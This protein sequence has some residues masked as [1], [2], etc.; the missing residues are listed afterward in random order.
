MTSPDSPR[1][2]RSGRLGLIIPFLLLA[3]FV[4]A[5]SAAWWQESGIVLSRLREAE[6]NG[7]GWRIAYARVNLS[8]F[9]FRLD[10]DFDSP[11]VAEP[12]GWGL[13]AGRLKAEAF[14]FSPTHWVIVAP[15]GVIVTRP[16]Q[17]PLFV[18]AKA[19]R[20]SISEADRHPPRVSVEGLD[21]T[22]S[23]APG[24]RPFFIDSAH[25]LHIHTRSGPA[26]QGAAYLEVDDARTQLSGLLARIA[27]G[28]P[29]SFI[30][31]GV[32]THASALSGPSLG[33]AVRGW[34]DAGG[35]LSVRR[36]R[37]GAGRALIEAR[38]GVLRA[39]PTGRLSGQ[40]S[41]SLRQADAV[42]NGLAGSGGLDAQ[43]GREIGEVTGGAAV[44]T[45]PLALRD[46]R[47]RLGPIDIGPSPRLF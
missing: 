11:R 43:R 15:A 13:Q 31:D 4:V 45:L 29:V 28:G 6:G 18:A 34:S 32:F 2:Q 3:L 38:P 17:G 8:G 10:L 16:R 33:D 26:D 25:E 21:L 44:A 40:L 30:A 23:T 47:V 24:A 39:G 7:P 46:G 9:P 37:L 20:A 42:A 27:A 14:V 12:S 5:V 35:D 1:R 41:V 36:L 19:L 22:F